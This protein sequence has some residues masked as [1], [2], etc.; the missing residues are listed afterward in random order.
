M[1]SSANATHIC[2]EMPPKGNEISF[3]LCCV[4]RRCPRIPASRYYRPWR[5]YFSNKVV[6]PFFGE[7]IARRC[8]VDTRFHD[9]NVCQIRVP[10]LNLL[11][12]VR[13]GRLGV[14]HTHIFKRNVT[15]DWGGSDGPGIPCIFPHGLRR[16]A[17][18]CAPTAFTT[19]SRTSRAKRV[20][21]SALPP[22]WSVRV[23]LAS[24][25]NW[26][27]RKPLAP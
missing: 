7:R 24:S 19:A 14:C 20:R 9:M 6:G 22:Y 17:V 23:L 13:V 2:N 25:R 21:F 4:N 10:F 1:M 5:P 16:I 26:L 15:K 18:R 11:Y 8:A 3:L 12:E 27:T